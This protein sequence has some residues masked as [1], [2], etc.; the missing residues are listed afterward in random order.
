MS[1]FSGFDKGFIGLRKILGLHRFSPI[2]FM[3]WGSAFGVKRDPKSLSAGAGIS[4]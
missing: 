2:F 4:V 1:F 3:V